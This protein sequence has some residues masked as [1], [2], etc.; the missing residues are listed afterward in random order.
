MR[1]MT[2]RAPTVLLALSLL[3]WTDVTIADHLPSADTP[4]GVEY[5]PPLD[6]ARR[7]TEGSDPGSIAVD[8]RPPLFGVGIG[9]DP[10]DGSERAGR[11]GRQGDR[12][13]VPGTA[14]QGSRPSDLARGDASQVVA[15]RGVGSPAPELAGLALAVLLC[16]VAVGLTLRR[17]AQS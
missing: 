7:R 8:A 10:R 16:G 13:P 3:G 6:D 5:A 4:A 1:P 15:G 12:P 17:R 2:R 9:E 14:R 11:S